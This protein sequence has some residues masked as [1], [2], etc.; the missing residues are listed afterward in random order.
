MVKLWVRLQAGRFALQLEIPETL[1]PL[2]YGRQHETSSSHS[3][4]IELRGLG[5]SPDLRTNWA[6]RPASIRKT[7]GIDASADNTGADA[8]G[9]DATGRQASATGKDATRI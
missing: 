9:A 2:D 6:T 7:I 3:R 4:H 8:T 5:R 1:K